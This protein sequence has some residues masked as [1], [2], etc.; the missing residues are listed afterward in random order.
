MQSKKM[1][2]HSILNSSDPV[3]HTLCKTLMFLMIENNL[4]NILGIVI[5]KKI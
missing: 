3:N 2:K 4:E 5:L 1:Y